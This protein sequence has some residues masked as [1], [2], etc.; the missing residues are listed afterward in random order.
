MISNMGELDIFSLL[1]PD[2]RLYK[3][4]MMQALAKSSQSDSVMEQSSIVVARNAKCFQVLEG[5]LK[6]PEVK[7][8][9]I[10]TAPCTCGIWT[11]A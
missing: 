11:S 1:N 5:V 3:R 4:M 7:R 6:Q 8:V 9:A 10:F 2:P